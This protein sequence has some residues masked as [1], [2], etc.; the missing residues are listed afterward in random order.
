M[1]PRTNGITLIR[2][3]ASIILYHDSM[4]TKAE[5]LLNLYREIPCVTPELG[6]CHVPI[7]KQG[8]LRERDRNRRL[9]V[10]I[11]YH[12]LDMQTLAYLMVDNSHPE[13]HLIDAYPV[14][15]T[16]TCIRFEHLAVS[17]LP[18]WK[19]QYGEG[20]GSPLA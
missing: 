9:I 13:A 14:C 1:P 11:E 3:H 17:Y 15:M 2:A 6:P 20:G 4:Q 16:M 12:Q 5:E 8:K 7:T 19:N 10:C 18:P